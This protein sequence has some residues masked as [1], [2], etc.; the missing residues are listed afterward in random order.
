MSDD[1]KS[2]Q[3]KIVQRLG[4]LCYTEIFYDFIK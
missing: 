1:A 2:E 4:R 3:K